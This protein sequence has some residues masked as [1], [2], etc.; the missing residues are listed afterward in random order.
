MLIRRAAAILEILAIFIVAMIAGRYLI[1]ASGIQLDL[2][3]AVDNLLLRW[4]PLITLA[5]IVDGLLR[6]RGASWGLHAT[7]SVLEG[8]QVTAR[9]LFLGGIIPLVVSLPLAVPALE[10]DMLALVASLAIPLVGQELYLLG[11]GHRRLSD[12]FGPAGTAVVIAFFFLLA[13][14]NHATAT[15]WGIVFLAAM[16]WQGL[17]WSAARSAGWGLL[18]LMA[19]HLILLLCYLS[20]FH[21]LLVVLAAGLIGL[22]GAR[23]WAAT[24]R[25]SFRESG[26]TAQ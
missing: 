11:F 18:P 8:A 26:G 5:L 21:G 22:P 6:R 14:A 15:P 7:G 16:G 13:H 12:T 17:L 20:P 24:L 9:L 3:D 2:P 1:R 4:L 10:T 19:A 23:A 25:A